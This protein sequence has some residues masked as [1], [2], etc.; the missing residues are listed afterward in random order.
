MGLCI[1]MEV[2]ET[3]WELRRSRVILQQEIRDF[4]ADMDSRYG[5]ALEVLQGD[6]KGGLT[7][8]VQEQ[9]VRAIII[10]TRRC[11]C[12]QKCPCRR[13]RLQALHVCQ[14]DSHAGSN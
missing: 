7:R 9:G 13:C 12:K 1:A 8:M 4:L 5:L 6:F 11:A 3:G 14:F 10:G 2:H